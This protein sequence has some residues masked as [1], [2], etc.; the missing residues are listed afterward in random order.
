[1]IRP[2]SKLRRGEPT[3]QEKQ[4]ARVLCCERAG[5]VCEGCGRYLPVWVGQLHHEH[6]KRRFGWMESET[7]RHLWLCARC[8]HETH[9]PKACPAKP[10]SAGL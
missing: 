8:H 6:S 3:K 7:Q 2:R 4:D 1:M 10:I 5:E 9:N